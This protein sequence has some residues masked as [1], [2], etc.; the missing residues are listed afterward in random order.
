MDGTK[1]GHVSNEGNFSDVV[2]VLNSHKHAQRI[3]MKR[4]LFAA[5]LSGFGYL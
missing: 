2:D 1:S 3:A 4:D 5:S